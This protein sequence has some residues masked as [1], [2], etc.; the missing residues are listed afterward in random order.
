M[1]FNKLAYYNN[2]GSNIPNSKL[3]FLDSRYLLYIQIKSGAKWQFDVD[4]NEL[5]DPVE[6]IL[7]Y[8][9]GGNQDSNLEPY[10]QAVKMGEG[11]IDLESL[12][13][14]ILLD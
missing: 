9:R 2:L 4:I 6:W 8:K 5:L 10:D 11:W 13:I 14:I 1:Y 3:G 12:F 7:K